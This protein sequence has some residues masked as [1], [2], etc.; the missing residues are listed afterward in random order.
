[1]KALRWMGASLL[2]LV[3]GLLGLIGALLCVTLILAPVGIP[4]LLLAK[5]LFKTAGQLV[6]PRSVRHPLDEL[7]R[8]GS[9]AADRLKRKGS[10]RTAKTKD[11]V[12][13]AGTGAGKKG[14][15]TGK[16]IRKKAGKA[17]S[18]WWEALPGK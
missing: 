2:G 10:K 13:T 5:R 14:R 8:A 18:R 16:K 12:V 1:M 15:K 3:A 6:V 17:G 4:L 11:A 9:D 7:D